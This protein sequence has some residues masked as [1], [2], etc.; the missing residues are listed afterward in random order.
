MDESQLK[1]LERKKRYMK[2]YKKN[3]ALIS[4]LEKK[5]A[6][7]NDRIYKIKS[8]SFSAM[9]KG[10]NPIDIT[11]LIADKEELLG[12]ISRLKEKGKILKT[13]TLSIIDDLDDVRYAEILESFFVDCKTFEEISDEMGYTTRNIIK[14]YSEAIVNLSLPI[15]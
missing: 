6:D 2:R 10:G 3:K 4:R 7:L 14:I 1:E 13:E 12:R 15:Q 11:D 8:S 9:P 5:L